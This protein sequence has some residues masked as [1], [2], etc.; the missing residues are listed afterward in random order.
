MTYRQRKNSL[1]GQLQ[2]LRTDETVGELRFREANAKLK[3]K[4]LPLSRLVH[5]G[6]ARR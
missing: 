4:S 5:G 1:Q 6:F 2:R 3:T